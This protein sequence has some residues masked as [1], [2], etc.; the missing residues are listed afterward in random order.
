MY[1]LGFTAKVEIGLLLLSGIIVN[2]THGYL[3]WSQRDE[4][5]WSLSVHA[6]K[7]K[8]SYVQYVLAH[9]IGGG[10]FL[11]FARE[12]FMV[13]NDFD[14]LF[15]L[16]IFNYFFEVLQA[17][18]PSKGRTEIPHT[19]AAL[20]MWFAF[21]TIAIVATIVLPISLVFKLASAGT[22]IFLCLLL[23]RAFHDRQRLYYY[24]MTMIGLFFVSMILLTVGS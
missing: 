14:G 17:V 2:G 3:L 9:V 23:V 16:A 24:Q 7:H 11:L 18:L 21:L 13:R 5:K 20:I 8:V 10:I 12:L 4:R 19:V 1:Q 15:Y 6:V 22:I